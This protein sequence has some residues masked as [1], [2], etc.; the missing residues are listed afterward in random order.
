M[1]AAKNKGSRPIERVKQGESL[2]ACRSGDGR[3]CQEQRREK[4]ERDATAQW[5]DRKTQ[6]PGNRRGFSLAEPKARARAER[7]RCD[8]PERSGEKY[9]DR[10]RGKRDAG[11]GSIGRE[12][13]S[14]APDGL[15]HDRDGDELES[16][17]ETFGNRSSEC[18]CADSKGEQNQGRGMV[19]ANHAARPPNSPLPRRTPREK[20]TWL[21]A[22]PGRN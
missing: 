17:Q 1:A 9:N 21:E 3:R 15:C 6:V 13:P 19:K 12:S 11:T 10:N 22:G 8:L 7:N 16:V 2:R 20:P 4:N 18:G 5:G 14:H